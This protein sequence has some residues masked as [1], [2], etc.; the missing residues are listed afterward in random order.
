[1]EDSVAQ[2]LLISSVE[3]G[4]IRECLFMCSDPVG[5]LH[6]CTTPPPQQEEGHSLD[7]CQESFHPRCSVILPGAPGWA[8]GTKA[9]SQISILST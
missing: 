6:P 5:A 1:M 4:S 8:G 7:V 2:V 3:L 9:Y